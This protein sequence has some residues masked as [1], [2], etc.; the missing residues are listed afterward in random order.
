MGNGGDSNL[1]RAG[2]KKAESTHTLFVLNALSAAFWGG[3]GMRY[4][5]GSPSSTLPDFGRDR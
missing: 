1:G 4:E 3:G 2:L 5:G